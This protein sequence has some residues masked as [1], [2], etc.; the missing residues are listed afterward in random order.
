VAKVEDV[1][2]V[3]DA[4]EVKVIEIDKQGRVNLSHK[5]LLA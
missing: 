1:V 5:V 4:L 2:N 3:G